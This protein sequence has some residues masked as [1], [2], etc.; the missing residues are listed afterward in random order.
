[1][2]EDKKVSSVLYGS[3]KDKTERILPGFQRPGALKKQYNSFDLRTWN[4]RRGL[5]QGSAAGVI[6]GYDQDTNELILDGSDAHTLVYGSTGSLK[7][8]CVVLPTMKLL[9]YGKESMIVNDS[10]GELYDRMA[11]FLTEQGYQIKVLNFR[12]PGLGN[13]WNPFYIPFQYYLNGDIDRAAEF[14]NDIASIIALSQVSGPDPFWDYSAYDC[15]LGL[16]LLLFRY[17][18]E[19]RHPIGSANV[20][21]LIR[22]RRQL[23]Q[24]GNDVKGSPL[25]AWAQE[26]ELVAASLSGSV[27]AP[28]NT[29]SSILSV[30][31][32]KLRAFSI[33]PTLLDMLANNDVDIGR[34]G[35]EK[36][37]IFLITPD[38]KTTYH[39]LVSLFIKQ[40]YEY[41]IYSAVLDRGTLPLRINYILDEFSTL[42]AIHDFASMISA[43]RSRNIRFLLV[44]QSKNQLTHKYQEEAATIAANCAN[45]I[46]LTSRELDLLRDISALCGTNR[47][48]LPN[49]SV[50]DLQ[51]FSKERAEALVLAGRNRP[52]KVQFMDIDHLDDIF[53]G[54][55][56][57]PEIK[58]GPRSAR[59]DLNFQVGQ[60]KSSPPVHATI[61][62][63]PTLGALNFGSWNVTKPPKPQVNILNIQQPFDLSYKKSEPLSQ[64]PDTPQS[65]EK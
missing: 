46:F 30:V 29:R 34:V 3:E 2:Y 56:A 37:A 1:M 32:Q 11:G 20:S 44:A 43:A 38:E 36:T 53:G 64:D 25:W 16:I 28:S 51:H 63:T 59:I 39:R 13:S 54:T 7:T 12:A 6:L 23:F 60:P 40:S 33:Q 35:R 18:K 22:L 5:A 24:N 52:C 15:I 55:I 41:L 19:N 10:K 42:P 65:E 57:P 8:R 4:F 49:I 9:G 58:A 61:S 31:D 47:Q 50:Y 62:F 48:Q 21:N 26:E 45:W 27:N 17:C 14:A